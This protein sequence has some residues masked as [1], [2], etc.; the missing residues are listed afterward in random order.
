MK[1]LLLFI[2]LI[3]ANTSYCQFINYKYNMHILYKL[4]EEG[5]LH[6]ILYNNKEYAP[7][8][9]KQFTVDQNFTDNDDV[10]FSYSFKGYDQIAR[11][12][13]P[14]PQRE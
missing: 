10:N 11:I 13:N 1:K 2:I 3:L 14:C 8:M 5:E 7:I 4:G 6:S 9:N 12:C